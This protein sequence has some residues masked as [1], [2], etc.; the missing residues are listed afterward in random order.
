MLSCEFGNENEALCFQN[1]G[2]IHSVHDGLLKEKI[3]VRDEERW[4]KNNFACVQCGM[5][6]PSVEL[7]IDHIKPWS[8]GGKTEMKNLQTLCSKCNIGKSDLE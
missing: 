2:S 7:H 6:P 8:K 1:L 3:L 5:R 4:G